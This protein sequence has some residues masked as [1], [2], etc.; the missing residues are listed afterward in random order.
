[1]VQRKFKITNYE[2]QIVCSFKSGCHS[3]R[4]AESTKSKNLRIIISA[5][6]FF[7]AKILRLPSV[8]QDDR[9][10][11]DLGALGSPSGRAVSEAD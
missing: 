2:L 7:G 3:E 10:G 6:Q 5:K 4:S 1:M 8:A 9:G 11:R